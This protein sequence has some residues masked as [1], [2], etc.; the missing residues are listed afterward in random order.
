MENLAEG[1]ILFTDLEARANVGFVADVDKTL[2]NASMVTPDVPSVSKMDSIN[3]GKRSMLY[4]KW[5]ARQV[6]SYA[7]LALGALLLTAVSIA[8]FAGVAF[9]W[10]LGL[11]LAAWAF[12]G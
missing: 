2:L 10:Q 1:S 8:L 6:Y 12:G 5:I 11:T 7:L 4:L 9:G 3:G